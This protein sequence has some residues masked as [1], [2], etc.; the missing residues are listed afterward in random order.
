MDRNLSTKDESNTEK[1]TSLES[2]FD[3]ETIMNAFA[4]ILMYSTILFDNQMLIIDKHV[5]VV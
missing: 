2:I 5:H 3:Q 1:Q 4:N